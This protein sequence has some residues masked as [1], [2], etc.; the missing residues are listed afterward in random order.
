MNF[1]KLVAPSYGGPEVLQV[2]EEPIPE[3]GEGEVLLRMVAAGVSFADVMWMSGTVP[4]GPKTPFT[5]G[6]DVVGTVQKVGP[7]VSDLAVG[8]RVAAQVHYGG[9]AEYVVVP[10]RQGVKLPAELDPVR[11]VCAILNYLT[12]YQIYH[13]VAHVTDQ[14]GTRVLIHGA[15]G[16]VGT[17][18]LDLGRLFGYEM[19]GTAR[20]SKQG[21]VMKLGGTPIDYE[22]E[23]FVD[24]ILK[25]TRT[26]VDLVIDPIGGP[27]FWQSFRTLRRGGILVA[28]ASMASV[29]GLSMLR[30]IL[31]Y[32]Q[33]SLWDFLP[34]GRSAT[35][36]DLEVLNEKNPTWY[37]E[38]LPRVLRYLAEGQIDPIVARVMP[39]TKAAEAH[40][41]LLDRQVEGKIVLV[42][43]P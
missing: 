15:A 8:E 10:S 14:P 35:F 5:P 33:V 24:G 43:G 26:G 12:A 4:G 22:A 6:Y 28:T 30:T 25:R 31:Y 32:M 38:D 37:Q 13:R 34:N 17:A 20:K 18:L 27:H 23:D 3:P 41:L 19:Y 11:A 9:Y 2:V 1:K 39:L 16:G 21:V 29:R 36:L 42:P 7:G 40:R